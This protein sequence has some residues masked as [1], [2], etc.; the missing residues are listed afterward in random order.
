LCANDIGGDDDYLSGVWTTFAKAT[1]ECDGMSNMTD[2]TLSDDGQYLLATFV[3]KDRLVEWFSG[4]G[5]RFCISEGSSKFES[6]S[7]YSS[8]FAT[9]ALCVY[10]KNSIDE[11]FAGDYRVQNDDGTSAWHTETNQQRS[12]DVGIVVKIKYKTNY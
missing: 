11:V 5:C 6:S 4:L 3:S 8:P 2:V 12:F 1:I 10:N 7:F 9:S